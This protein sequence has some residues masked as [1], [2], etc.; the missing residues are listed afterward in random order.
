MQRILYSY[1]VKDS[2]IKRE[3][4]LTLS[5]LCFIYKKALDIRD[6]FIS[7][8]L[9]SAFFFIIR[10]YKCIKTLGEPWSKIIISNHINFIKIKNKILLSMNHADLKASLVQINFKMQKNLDQDE[11]VSNYQSKLDL[12]PI[13]S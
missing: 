6:K 3:Q 2:S 7:Y 12:C 9:T 11:P 13:C 5:I 1:Y 4:P 8:L 10:S